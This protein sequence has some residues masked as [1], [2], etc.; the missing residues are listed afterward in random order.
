[1]RKTATALLYQQG[2]KA[3]LITAQGKG[4][5][6][7]KMLEIAHEHKIPVI[8]NPETSQVLSLYEIGDYIP[9]QTYEIIAKILA[10]VRR[11]ET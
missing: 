1:M 10:F 5:T 4:E 9:E 6:A 7:D 2:C 11:V 8:V 3:P